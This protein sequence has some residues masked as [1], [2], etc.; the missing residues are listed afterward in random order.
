MC[1]AEHLTAVTKADLVKDT[2]HFIPLKG[3]TH[4]CSTTGFLL[5]AQKPVLSS[6][7]ATPSLCNAEMS[8][9]GGGGGE[10]AWRAGRRVGRAHTS[11]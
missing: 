1:R 6:E 8:F 9:G 7:K 3:G 5:F 4:S 2:E 10:R 11:Q